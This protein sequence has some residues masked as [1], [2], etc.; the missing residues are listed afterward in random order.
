MRFS[1]NG[2]TW[3]SW[4][5]Y[6]TPVTTFNIDTGAGC[7]NSDGTKTVYVQFEDSLLNI[8]SAYNTG[9]FTLD[10]TNPN[11]ALSN[12]PATYGIYTASTTTDI[13]VAGT[14]VVNYE[15]K[16]DSGSI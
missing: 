5:A 10:T 1:C 3:S 11:A 14:D 8:G 9:T 4:A 2:S 15:Y 6:A 7:T 12:T 13:A 16:L